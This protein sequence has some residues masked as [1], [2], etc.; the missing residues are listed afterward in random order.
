ME[1]WEV[2]INEMIEDKIKQLG[3]WRKTQWQGGRV[4]C[5]SQMIKN[6]ISKFD[7]NTQI[8]Y[9]EKLKLRLKERNTTIQDNL[10]HSAPIITG[11]FLSWLTKHLNILKI[12]RQLSSQTE[13]NNDE[14]PHPELFVSFKAWKVFETFVKE[15]ESS[16]FVREFSFI[17]RMMKEREEPSLIHSH[18]TP[19]MYKEWF[20]SNMK[21]F[22]P[23]TEIKT[24]N[25]SETKNNDRKKRYKKIRD[26]YFKS[27]SLKK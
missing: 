16:K 24:F 20:N 2:F 10:A 9:L 7:V 25:D 18:V 15:S 1:D 3:T 21:D 4:Y 22:E 23:L 11:E 6:E 17:Y 26:I 13:S 8:Y 19:S 27:N 14:N 12:N 5:E